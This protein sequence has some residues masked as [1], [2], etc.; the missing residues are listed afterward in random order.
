[1]DLTLFNKSVGANIPKQKGAE[2]ALAVIDQKKVM[3]T[4]PEVAAKLSPTEMAIAQAGVLDLIRFLPDN[5]LIE[6]V[7][8]LV[9]GICQDVGIRGMDK[10]DEKAQYD[11][12]RFF[13]V[14]KKY[15]GDLS[16]NEVKAAFELA[17][18]GTLDEYLPKDREGNPDKNHYQAFNLEYYSKILNAYRKKKSDV[19]GKVRLALPVPEVVISEEE[20]QRNH[21][22]LINEIYDAY[23]AYQ[24]GVSPNFP[25]SIYIK[26][27]QAQN[28]IKE[29][30]VPTKKDYEKAYRKLLLSDM[31]RDVKKKIRTEYEA[32]KDLKILK[33]S[34]SIKTEA[35]L[36]VYNNAI[37]KIFDT[38]IAQGFD[39]IEKPNGTNI[40][41]NTDKPAD[42]VRRRTKKNT[43]G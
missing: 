7:K 2:R 30:P 14:L 12:T 10:E 22:F 39:L 23:I 36:T 5:K 34:G 43:P 31:P 28:H 37:A 27:L 13:T 38:W 17:A 35:E 26:E 40:P 16:V 9:W 20:R 33:T 32:N 8:K 29:L 1:M 18:V 11:R 21:Q 41:Q 19:W 42:P 24:K 6:E 4:M 15:Y 3:L 25:L